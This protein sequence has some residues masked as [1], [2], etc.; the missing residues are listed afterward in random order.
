MCH[1]KSF[2]HASLLEKIWTF[3]VVLMGIWPY[4]FGEI[5]FSIVEIV[6][7]YW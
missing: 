2:M 5:A 1:Y 7:F 6:R 4:N 3:L